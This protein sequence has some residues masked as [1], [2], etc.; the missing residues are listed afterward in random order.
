MSGQEEQFPEDYLRILNEHGL[1]E[2]TNRPETP[3]EAP[4]VPRQLTPEE[5]SEQQEREELLH[6]KGHPVTAEL[7]NGRVLVEAI[8]RVQ[9]D[10]MPYSLFSRQRQEDVHRRPKVRY[11]LEFL[12]RDL[13]EPKLISRDY[14]MVAGGK[15]I[16][17]GIDHKPLP[18]APIITLTGRDSD[19]FADVDKKGKLEL[20]HE[21]LPE[22][23]IEPEMHEE[24]VE[25][26]EHSFPASQHRHR[27]GIGERTELREKPRRIVG[28]TDI[29]S[30]PSSMLGIKGTRHPGERKGAERRIRNYTG[31][32]IPLED[33]PEDRHLKEH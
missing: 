12:A 25:V 3:P 32:D 2:P 20:S 10:A 9:R 26:P 30:M 23:V 11:Q 5:L 1:S 19:L 16:L 4:A 18:N 33:L 15:V 6:G 27:L 24:L 7:E 8:I 14:A 21:G 17:T 13:F 31:K 29:P 22:D 28:A